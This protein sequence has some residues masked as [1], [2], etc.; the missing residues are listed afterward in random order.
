MEGVECRAAGAG[1]RRPI[2]RRRCCRKLEGSTLGAVG[3]IISPVILSVSPY[4]SS[5]A[6]DLNLLYR[7][8]ECLGELS[9]MRR[10]MA[11]SCGT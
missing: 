4:N 11:Y 8:Y 10:S 1:L 9:V 2:C 5:A 6:D 7:Q 3:F